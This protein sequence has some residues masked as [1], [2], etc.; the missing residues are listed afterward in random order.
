MD[1]TEWM[2]AIEQN[3]K[4]ASVISDILIRLNKRFYPSDFVNAILQKYDRWDMLDAYV[5]GIIWNHYRAGHI[6]RLD[7]PIGKGPGRDKEIE[8]NNLILSRLPGMFKAEFIPQV[9][10]G[11]NDDGFLEWK[12]P[13]EFKR[14]NDLQSITLDP[15]H[16]PLEVGSTDAVTTF[17]HM[18]LN[19]GVARWPYHSD[20]IILLYSTG[21]IREGR[22]MEV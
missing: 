22:I 16:L 9:G 19:F 4:W 14:A 21:E 10:C 3:P 7:I 8:G 2:M 18:L 11:A 5:F 6:L 13:V 12:Q 20:K 1:T 17:H 15:W